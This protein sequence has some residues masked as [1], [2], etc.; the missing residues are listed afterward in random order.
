MLPYQ[1]L[2]RLEEVAVEAQVHFFAHVDAFLTAAPVLFAR[3]QLL[4]TCHFPVGEAYAFGSLGPRRAAPLQVLEVVVVP[5]I[6]GAEDLQLGWNDG[7][8]DDGDNG[9]DGDGD[10]DD[11]N[12]DHD[13]DDGGENRDEMRQC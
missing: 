10:D 2:M 12:D 8:D 11:D 9:D 1:L 13:D 7:D 4:Q 5:F 3:G 6:W